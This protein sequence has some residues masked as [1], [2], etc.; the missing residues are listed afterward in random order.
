MAPQKRTDW[1]DLVEAAAYLKLTPAEVFRLCV[2]DNFPLVASR[3][4]IDAWVE[5]R[6]TGGPDTTPPLRQRPQ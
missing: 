2:H 4:A 6:A 5:E 3:A 1:I